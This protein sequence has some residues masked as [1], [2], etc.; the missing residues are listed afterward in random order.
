MTVWESIE[1]F[2]PHHSRV[3]DSEAVTIGDPVWQWPRW[4]WP[5]WWL[6]AAHVHVG[7]VQEACKWWTYRTVRRRAMREG[8]LPGGDFTWQGNIGSLGRPV[9]S[10]RYPFV[11]VSFDFVKRQ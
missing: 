2:V 9:Y 1:L 10:W 11:S 3:S 4:F 8:G 6:L 7:L 5:L